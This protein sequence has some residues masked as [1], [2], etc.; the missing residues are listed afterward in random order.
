MSFTKI[1]IAGV[2]SE[3][4]KT[5]TDHPLPQMV[6]TGASPENFK[7]NNHER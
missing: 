7:E 6:L 5:T 4:G 3:V 1:A 2:S